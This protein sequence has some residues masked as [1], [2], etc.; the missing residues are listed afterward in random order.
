MN[1]D[2]INEAVAYLKEKLPITPEVGIILGSGLGGIADAIE[3]P[4]AVPYGDIPNFAVST[5]PGHAGRFIVGRLSGKNVIAMQGRLHF[6]EGHSLEKATFPV[7][8]MKFL[9]IKTLVV[10]N[11]AGGINESFSIGDI[12]LIE[13]HINFM[14]T[15]PFIGP[16]N[17][18]LGPRFFDM[19]YTYTERLRELAD[20]TARELDIPINHGVYLATTGPSYETPAEIRAFRTLGADAVGMSTV[21]EA[22]TASYLKLD[23]LAFSLITNMAAGVTRN[24]LSEEEVIEIGQQKGHVLQRLVSE[25]IKKL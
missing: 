1:I 16:N 4:T 15:N 5:A 20:E 2:K 22:I 13:D 8:V 24:K 6:Y 23:L 12:M 14:G 3:E 17:R 11:A 21:P 19:T 18:D 7:Y 9:G 25:I 10:T